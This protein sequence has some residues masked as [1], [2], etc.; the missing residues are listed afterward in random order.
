MQIQIDPAL[1]EQFR[2]TMRENF[3][4]GSIPFRKAY[5]QALVDVIEVD[6]H[7]IRIKGSKDLL[8][9]AVLASKNGPSWSSQMNTKWRAAAD[10]DGQYCFA[11]AL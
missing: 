1:I 2:R 3:S 4:T 10:E 9:K 5:L 8:D 11:V 7:L 6:D